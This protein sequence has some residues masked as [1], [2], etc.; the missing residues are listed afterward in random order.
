MARGRKLI[1]VALRGPLLEQGWTPRAAGC[2]TRLVAPGALGVLAVGV[3]SEHS[4]PGSA[5]ATL[6][7]HLRDEQLE[8]D[9][10]HLTGGRDQGYRTPTATTSIGYL[11][12]A[13]RWHEW[14]VGPDSADAV[15]SEMAEAADAYS[16]PHLRALVADPLA[17]LAARAS[18]ASFASPIGRARAVLLLRR[19]GQGL[20]AAEFLERRVS[21][22]AARSGAAAEM[23]RRVIAAL[24]SGAP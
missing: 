9:V 16:E 10:A 14:N 15:A 24:E 23:E 12:P 1:Q 7:V 3:A 17:L 5:R 21:E 22:L 6:H 8:A 11:M 4:A 18:S 2:F 13:A 20:E 19:T